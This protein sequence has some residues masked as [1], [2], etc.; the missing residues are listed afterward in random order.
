M[1]ADVIIIGGGPSGLMAA[2]SAGMEGLKVLLVDKGDS[3]GRKLAISGGGRCNVTNAG[4]IDFIIKNIPGNGKFLYSALSQFSN[5]DIIRLFEDFGISLKEEDRGRMFPVSN[6]AKDVVQALLK[7]INELG[8]IIR[9]NSP[10]QEILYEDNRVKGVQ[11]HSGEAIEASAVIVAVGGKSVPYTGSTGDG[12]EWAEKAGHTITPLFPTEVPILS[13]ESFIQNKT[14]QGLS[15]RNIRLAVIDPKK[16]KKLIEH[17]G[18]MIFTHF[19][20][21]GPTALRCSQF[22]VKALKKHNLNQILM[23]LD[24]FPGKS[25]ETIFKEIMQRAE[26]EPKKAIKNVLKGYLP[27]RLIP[28]LLEKAELDENTTFAHLPKDPLE[29]FA[30]L[31]KQF[32]I[33]VNGTLS[34]EEAFVTGGGVSLKEVDPKTMESKSMPGLFFCGEILDIHGYTGG[35]NITAAFTTGYSAGKGAVSYCRTALFPVE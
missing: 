18:D 4:D 30:E 21:S 34:I 8:V 12:Y 10:V 29:K 15:L 11:L 7:K 14:L 3:L 26:Q 2:L 33:R 28:V 31:I 32:P 23:T 16:N 1:K 24:V 6:K 20:L 13:H 9:K 35:F 27:E 19:G 22:V 17:E 5:Q 25:K